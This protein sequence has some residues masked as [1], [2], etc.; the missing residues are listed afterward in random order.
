MPELRKD[1]VRNSWVIIVT[2]WALKPADFPINK[3]GDY[4]INDRFCPFCVGH[5]EYTTPEITAC[6]LNCSE[7]N[8]PGWEIRTIPSKFSAFKLEGELQCYCDGVFQH[9][10]GPGQQ[11]VI[12]ETPVHDEEFHHHSVDKLKMIYKVMKERYT[13]LAS[14]RRIKYIQIYKNRGLF[15]GAS[16]EHSHSQIIGL[17]IIPDNSPGITRYY[18]EKKRCLICDI[19][20]GEIEKKERIVYE[21]EHF[22][23][24]CPYASRFSYETWILPKRHSRHFNEISPPEIADLASLTKRFFNAMLH[25]LDNPSYNLLINSAPVNVEYDSEYHWYIEVTPR[26]MVP[27]GMEIV[28]GYHFNPAAPEVSASLLRNQI[29]QEEVEV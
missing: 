6:R 9:G 13:Y 22:V 10:M 4:V 19:V 11:E 7:P 15:A 3:N 27:N 21:S 24:L 5:E 12:I 20:A 28:T 16:Q 2:D 17:P 18:K 1:L 23:V 26:L 8:T 14:D 25:C 29:L